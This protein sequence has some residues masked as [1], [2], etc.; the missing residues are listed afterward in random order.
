[1]AEHLKFYLDEHVSQA[2]AAGLRRRGV[3][4][5]T[6]LDVGMLGADDEAHL[7]LATEQG[8]IIFTQD[9]DFLRL[10]AVGIEHSGIIY[11]PQQTSI[12]YILRGL[13]LIYEVLDPADL[14]NRVEFL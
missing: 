4:V 13:M 8:R 1:M 6:V 5:L 12:G 11:V 3:D 9:A 14:R 10:H 2:V 7:A